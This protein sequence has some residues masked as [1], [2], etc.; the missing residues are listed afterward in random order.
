MTALAGDASPTAPPPLPPDAAAAYR[1][2]QAAQLA[3]DCKAL[4]QRCW[5][6]A[7]WL[8]P[9]WDADFGDYRHQR[10]T[11]KPLAVGEYCEASPLLEAWGESHGW[12]QATPAPSGAAGG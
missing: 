10:R 5:A 6:E 9:V 2:G 12:D 4:C 8:P 7:L 1:A 11:G 3:A